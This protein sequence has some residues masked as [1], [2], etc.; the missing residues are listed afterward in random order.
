MVNKHKSRSKFPYSSKKSKTLWQNKTVRKKQKMR[1][2][3]M[4]FWS[5]G[6]ETTSTFP[7]C[8]RQTKS[9][10]RQQ[11]HASSAKVHLRFFLSFDTR[12]TQ[13]KKNRRRKD[14]SKPV[15]SHWQQG[16]SNRSSK[17][18]L[19]VSIRSFLSLP[20]R[21][22]L[23]ETTITQ[24]P[25]APTH[26]WCTQRTRFV[27]ESRRNSSRRAALCTAA[28]IRHCWAIDQDLVY[29]CQPVQRPLLRVPHNGCVR[30]TRCQLCGY[31]PHSPRQKVSRAVHAPWRADDL[32]H[33]T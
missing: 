29:V 13:L 21:R 11:S 32:N 23:S 10:Q 31:S 22:L 19:R 4:H 24:L 18:C 30:N 27:C 7:Q 25:P 5:F 12:K 20:W 28:C 17:S 14:L 15:M 8:M 9:N 16:S 3:E 2:K 6:W 33:S 1:S 26:C